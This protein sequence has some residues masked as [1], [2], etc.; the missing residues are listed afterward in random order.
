MK[1]IASQTGIAKSTLSLWLREYPL[2]D[3]EI[4][5]RK[6][7]SRL[8]NPPPKRELQDRTPFHQTVDVAQLPRQTKAKVAEAAVLFRLV[9]HGFNAF[10]SVFDGDKTDWLVEVPETN[11]VWKIQVRWAKP[12]KEGVPTLRLQ[13]SDG[14]TKSRRF[15]KEEFDFIV[16]YYLK[17]DTAYVFSQAETQTHDYMI[18]IR[19]DAAEAWHKLKQD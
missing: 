6:S 12:R 10:G 9:L 7:C 5:D 2:E 8:S 4:H 3:D 15:Q 16:A 18:S 19:D 14:R 17:N 1:K 11:K 13:C